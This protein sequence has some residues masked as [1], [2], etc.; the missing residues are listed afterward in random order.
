MTLTQQEKGILTRRIGQ[1]QTFFHNTE[2]QTKTNEHQETQICILN[3]SFKNEYTIS[4]LSKQF[5]SKVQ[6]NQEELKINGQT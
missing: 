5:F 2:W 1:F 3:K 6:K 4:I